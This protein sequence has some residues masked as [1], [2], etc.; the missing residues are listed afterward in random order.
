MGPRKSLRFDPNQFE[1]VSSGIQGLDEITQGGLPQGRTT[2]ICGGAGCGK[3]L[4]ALK[5]L[6]SGAREHNEP[7][8]FVSF[9]ETEAE[10]TKNVASLHFDLKRLEAQKKLIVEYI[11][12][13]R[14]EIEEAGA[15]SL[16]GLFV[17]LGHAIDSIGAKRVVLDTIEVLFSGLNNQTVLRSEIRRL[18]RWLKEKGVTAIIT[19]ERGERMLTLHGLEEFISDCVI[20]LDHRVTEQL[21]TRRIRVVKYRGS[22]HGTNE[23][24]FLINKD[25]ISVLPISS[26]ELNH[27]GTKKRVSTGIRDL[28]LMFGGKGYMKGSSILVSGSAGTGKTTLAVAFAVDTCKRG[29]R[30]LYLSFEESPGQLIQNMCSVNLD[31]GYWVSRGLLKIIAIRPSVYGLEMHLLEIQKAIEDFKPKAVIID[32]LTS[33]SSQ[34]QILEIQSMII[35][36][37]DLLKSKGITALFTS[38]ISSGKT[39]YENSQVG[40]SS[41]I[42]TWIVVRELEDQGRRTRG[43]YIIKSRGMAHSNEVQKLVF[44]EKGIRLTPV[45]GVESPAIGEV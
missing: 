22:S 3:T 21:S 16:D 31:L 36:V 42:D 12:I 15:Y 26:L 17:R 38:L 29:G 30:C 37:V 1:K 6:V 32:P 2:L 19:S 10:L 45:E 28:D 20:L 7:G 41:L 4:F 39:D 40:V 24:P 18:F 43:L 23:Y 8:V 5:F 25:G 13:E 34:G 27:P 14:S 33:L 9:E 44:S 11:Y 35:R